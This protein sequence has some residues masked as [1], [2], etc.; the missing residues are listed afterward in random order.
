[1]EAQ[2][3]LRDE[4]TRV[5]AV[6]TLVRILL[7]S[8]TEATGEQASS[9]GA[10][11]KS[12]SP[13]RLLNGESPEAVSKSSQEQRSSLQERTAIEGHL[14]AQTLTVLDA[15]LQATKDYTVNNRCRIHLNLLLSLC[16]TS[17]GLQIQKY[18]V[19]EA[20]CPWTLPHDCN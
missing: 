12:D 16:V 7:R 20:T 19:G 4:E 3:E 1:M 2:T 5:H 6:S 11:V 8:L 18:D 14:S 17:T 10:I 15:L 13:H 9:G